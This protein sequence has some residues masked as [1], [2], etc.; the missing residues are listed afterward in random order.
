MKLKENLGSLAI[1]IIVFG[2]FCV[3]LPIVLWKYT[4][5]LSAY[6]K[7]A[8]IVVSWP[9]AVVFVAILLTMRFHDALDYFLRNCSVKLPGGTEI[10]SQQKTANTAKEDQLP[11]GCAILTRE[12][13][14]NLDQFIRDIRQQAQL[15][16]ADAGLLNQELTKAYDLAINWKFNYL[17]LFLVQMTKEILFWFSQQTASMSRAN[18]HNVWQMWIPDVTQRDTILNVLLEFGML[19]ASGDQLSATPHGRGF[20]AFIGRLPMPTPQ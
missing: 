16:A 3:C 17:N 12:Q 14:Q 11:P 18:Y 9:T 15:N 8:S 1:L 4:P 10:Q 6:L 5:D 13:Q 19:Q 2:F 20:L 7:V